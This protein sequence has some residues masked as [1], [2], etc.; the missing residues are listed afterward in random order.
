MIGCSIYAQIFDPLQMIKQ[1]HLKRKKKNEFVLKCF[2]NLCED[3]IL[4]K[5]EKYKVLKVS[6]RFCQVVNVFC[7]VLYEFC[8]GCFLYENF[9]SLGYLRDVLQICCCLTIR[10]CLQCA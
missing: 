3:C 2:I 4:I 9:D 1:Q 7:S 5:F 8:F 6:V 10:F